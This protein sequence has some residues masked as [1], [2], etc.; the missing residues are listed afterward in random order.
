MRTEQEEGEGGDE[1]DG[2]G[3]GKAHDEEKASKR[4]KLQHKQQRGNEEKGKGHS[5]RTSRGRAHHESP[6]TYEWEVGPD[7]SASD[8]ISEIMEWRNR[9]VEANK[10]D[11]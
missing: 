3:Q 6:S 2:G 10:E 8:F 5:G 9:V 1:S 11:E 7:K 4:P